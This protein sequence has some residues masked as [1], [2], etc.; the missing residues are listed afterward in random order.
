MGL[1]TFPIGVGFCK[2]LDIG[3]KKPKHLVFYPCSPSL[4]GHHSRLGYRRG[5]TSPNPAA[6]TNTPKLFG[7]RLESRGWQPALLETGC[8]LALKAG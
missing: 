4:H 7:A 5:E 2:V 8:A 3:E 1:Q 6:R